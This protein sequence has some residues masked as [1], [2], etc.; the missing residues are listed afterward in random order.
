MGMTPMER[1]AQAVL[2]MENVCKYYQGPDGMVRALDGVSFV[3]EAG[4]FVALQGPSGCGKTTLLLA[5]G[6]LLAPSDGTVEVDG[7]DI[8]RLRPEERARL[9]AG[10]IGFVFQQYHLIPYLTVLENVMAAALALPKDEVRAEAMAL[11]ERF[12]LAG[13]AYHVPA[14]LSS[15][16][17]QR[18]AL[19]RALLN[20]PKLVLADEVTGNLDRA[21]AEA[22]L[23][24]L[25]W[26]VEQGGAVLM[27]THSEEA[28]ARA[29]RCVH[30][31]AGKLLQ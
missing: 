28:A 9:R 5:A 8:Y 31:Q 27:A 30:M 22:V 1:G 16:E 4:Q 20:R 12:G 11:I 10:T 21:N 17:R 7:K 13:R 26:Y 18:T 23:G 29:G 15:G 19:A 2:V 6:G 3:V 14:E 25:A 24:Y